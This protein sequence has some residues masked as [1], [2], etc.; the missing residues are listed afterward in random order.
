MP[1]PLGYQSEN[2]VRA[3]PFKDNC[4]L[5]PATGGLSKL[6]D[7]TFIDF[8]LVAPYPIVRA[9]LTRLQIS[10]GGYGTTVTITITAYRLNT[11]TQT[12][13]STALVVSRDLS[14]LVPYETITYN[15]TYKMK[16]VFGNGLIRMMQPP[17]TAQL[18]TFEANINTGQFGAEFTPSTIIWTGPTVST[19]AFK[20][21]NES[22]P[23]ASMT[24]SGVR[25]LQAGS[26]I[27]FGEL[28]SA[29]GFNV[30]KGAGTG[31]Y[32]PCADNP[33][34]VIKSINGVD[35]EDFLFT[36]GDCYKT[37]PLP[38]ETALR[39]EHTCRPKCTSTEVRAAA[40]YENRLQDGVNKMGDYV[41][42]IIDA[43]NVQI[44]AKEAAK[45][46]QIISPY[47]DAQAARTVFNLRNYESIG[48]G[49][50][51][52]NKK[53]M[54]VNLNA[55]FSN[56]VV[57]ESYFGSNPTW[58]SWVLYAGSPTLREE[59]NTY[60]LPAIIPG[61][62]DVIQLLA[63]RGVDCR[64]SALVNFVV[65]APTTA[66]DQWAKLVLTAYDGDTLLG[67]GFKYLNLAPT[68]RPYFNIRSRRGIRKGATNTYVHTV[69]IELFDSNPSWSGNTSF[70]AVVNSVHIVKTPQ[71]RI[72]NGV[73]SNLTTAGKTVAFSN[74]LIT[75]PDR[76]VV[77]F[78]LE[79][80]TTATVNLSLTMTVGAQQ[81]VLNN[82]TFS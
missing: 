40:Y 16:I 19:V 29:I 27:L 73:T 68:P 1:T 78:Q 75:W 70:S 59:N 8:Q 33:T 76:A 52:P 11:V 21:V 9:A 25:T 53:K 48:V 2:S 22:A 35:G 46:A 44:A 15:S 60:P 6:A 43:L 31:L 18:Y 54:T 45:A 64:G 42:G 62:N 65:S 71:L 10:T 23:V 74:R 14:Q 47:I 17:Y 80:T 69:M 34:D 41:K 79:A 24:M 30:K 38:D 58:P 12:W 49:I 5:I 55:Y 72:N 63:N 37:I 3:Y 39:F 81:T 51:D 7:D 56:G 50:Y 32:D 67:T 36:T 28:P 82:L 77:T 26:N 4:A 61:S 66:T 57:T 13:S 20:N